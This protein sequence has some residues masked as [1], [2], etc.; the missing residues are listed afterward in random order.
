MTVSQATASN[1][2]AEQLATYLKGYLINNSKNDLDFYA[3]YYY[4][5]EKLQIN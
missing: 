1:H 5:T 3:I 2:N 4:Y